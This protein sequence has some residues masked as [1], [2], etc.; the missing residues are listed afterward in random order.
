MAKYT[1]HSH[2]ALLISKTCEVCGRT[3]RLEK[4]WRVLGPPIGYPAKGI[5][6]DTTYYVCLSCA[7]GEDVLNMALISNL[8]DKAIRDNKLKGLPKPD[9]PPPPPP[10]RNLK[11]SE[12]PKV[13]RPLATRLKKFKSSNVFV[14]GKMMFFQ[15]VKNTGIEYN[16]RTLLLNIKLSSETDGLIE[17]IPEGNVRLQV[18]DGKLV[19]IRFHDEEKG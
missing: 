12:Q 18:T 14:T 5:Y 7:P 6:T 3:I 11:E 2:H 1:V 17:N 8:L 19:S 9:G 13:D 10:A 16:K 4:S 15:L